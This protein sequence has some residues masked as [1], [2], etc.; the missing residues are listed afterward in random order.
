MADANENFISE[1][2]DTDFNTKIKTRK[3]DK[4]TAKFVKGCKKNNQLK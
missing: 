2:T 1:E 4:K 3:I